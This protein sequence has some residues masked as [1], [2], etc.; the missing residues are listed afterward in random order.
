MDETS[1]WE[2]LDQKEEQMIEEVEGQGSETYD[3]F[4]N[5]WQDWLGN[6]A[7]YITRCLERASKRRKRRQVSGHQLELFYLDSI[8]EVTVSR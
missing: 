2:S 4:M 6:Q 8:D 3:E 1:V 5:T 7:N